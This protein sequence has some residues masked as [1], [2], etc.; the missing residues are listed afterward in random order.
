MCS[1]PCAHSSAT[2]SQSK[3]EWAAEMGALAIVDDDPRH[4][5]GTAS[6][7]PVRFLFKPPEEAIPPEGVTIVQGWNDLLE[8]LS[9][10]EPC[11]PGETL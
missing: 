3:A 5:V 6:T 2:F 8:H 11:A 4:L 7:I 10:L 1:P 9:E